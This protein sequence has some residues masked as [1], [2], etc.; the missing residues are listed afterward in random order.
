[1]Q[2]KHSIA[3]VAYLQQSGRVYEGE[4]EDIVQGQKRSKGGEQCQCLAESGQKLRLALGVCKAVYIIM[5]QHYYANW[6]LKQQLQGWHICNRPAKY[7][8]Y[9]GIV[10]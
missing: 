9:L 2:P 4:L 8:K 5:P 1:M 7:E 3:S 6:Q 10:R